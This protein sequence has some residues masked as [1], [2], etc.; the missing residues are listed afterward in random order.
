MT[1]APISNRQVA[2]Y[3][4]GD[5]AMNLYWS[6]TAFFL[7]YW[8]T[9]VAGVPNE[10]AGFLFFIGSAWDAVTDPAMGILAERT[11]TRWGRYRPYILLGSVP[12]AASFILLLWVPPFTGMALTGTLIAAHLLFRTAYT[13]VGVPYSALSARLTRDSQER[14]KLAGVR[15]LAAVSGGLAIS[16][17]AFPLVN[18]LGNGDERDG[19]FALGIVA[20]ILAVAVHLICFFNTREPDL[21]EQGV[22]ERPVQLRDVA[23]MV[24]SNR[25]FVL[26]FFA[27]LLISSAG[28]LIGKNVIYF[29]KYALGE[30]DRQHVV[31]LASGLI[32][33]LMVPVWTL[34]AHRIGKRN[35]WL[36]ATGIV[37]TGLLALFFANVATLGEFIAYMGFISLG[38]SAFG[39][40]FW[41]MLPDTVE[42]GEWRTGVR[43]EAIVFGFTTFAQKVSIGIAGWTLGYLLTATG[44]ESGEE[45]SA[46]T[47]QGLLFIMTLVPAALYFCA[48][49]MV[50][51]YP[52]NKSLHARIVDEIAQRQPAAAD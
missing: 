27:I 7:L 46:E 16:A 26:V 42:F 17:A 3:G 49:A 22:A 14:T 24:R 11:R 15:M 18:W 40:L 5:L 36:L 43:S 29:V 25:P 47:I 9:D 8:Y 1:P 13:L 50:W 19:F 4:V 34:I 6:G 32:G 38:L 12:L 35:G 31:V 20:G 23:N 48:A 28:V 37:I 52:L 44:Y 33:L 30:H 21:A 2:G 39:V 41:S 51:R 45:Q 10:A